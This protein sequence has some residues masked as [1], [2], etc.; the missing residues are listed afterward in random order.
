MSY[1]S[2]E[3]GHEAAAAHLRADAAPL[4]GR[5]QVQKI[6]NR[7]GQ[8]TS[9][10]ALDSDGQ[11]VVVRTLTTAD[12]AVRQSHWEHEIALLSLLSS[13][14]FA[15]HREL[16][17]HEETLYWVRPYVAGRALSIDPTVRP[18]L[19]QA[20]QFGRTL[21]GALQAL[22]SR[23]CLCRNLRPANLI[24]TDV[25]DSTRFVLTDFGLGVASDNDEA[26]RRTVDDVLYL[27]P[28]QAGS[29]DCDVA[30]T[31]DLYSAGALYFHYLSGRPPYEGA[32]V[33]AVLLRHMTAHVPKL[34]SLGLEMPRALD[35]VLQRLL[36]K[37]PRDRYQSAAAV[38]A[39]LERIAAA[40]EAGDADPDFVVGSADRRRTL[41]EPAF[42]G[43]AR[44][45]QQLDLQLKS[46]RLGLGGLVVLET[47]SGGGKS[48][49]LDE[50]TQRARCQGIWVLRGIGTNEVGQ[51]PFQV[52]DG[53]VQDFVAVAACEP[54]WKQ[55]LREQLGDRLCSVTAVLPQVA[56]VLGRDEAGELGPE[57]FAEARSIQALV[58]FLDAL[59]STNRPALVVLDD[60]Q[61]AD[62]SAVKLIL[63]WANARGERPSGGVTVVVAYRSEEVETTHALR[64]LQP[65]LQLR[66]AKFDDEDLR[67]LIE[68]MAGP[69][70]DD[71][72]EAVTS[73]A[74][75]S[76]FMASAALRGLV[77]SG[78]VVA[79]EQGWRIEPL[80]V[81]DMQSSQQAGS[82]LARRIDLLPQQ[83]A[84][85]LSAGAVLGKEF[86][87]RTAV[88]LAGLDVAVALN[89]L[90]LARER[91][92][93]WMRSDGSRCA[94]VHD[95]I[96]ATLLERLDSAE[97]K[98]LHL[99]AAVHLRVQ[100][101]R[102]T[103]ELAY[104][105]DAADEPQQ[106]L[107]FALES[108]EQARA[109][110][111]LETAEQQ[112]Q[113][114]L[115]GA[116]TVNRATRYR[117]LQGLGDVQMLRGRYAPSAELFEQAAEL[118]EGPFAQAEIR[119]KLGELAFKRG[120]IDRAVR[121]FEAAL[122]LLSCYVPRSLPTFFLLF[123]WEAWVQA[124]HTLL[125]GWF[126]GRLKRPPTDAE[127]LSWRLRS[128]LAFGYW[129]A[130]SK[131]HVLWT[132]LR[133]MNLGER[134]PPTLELAQAYSEHAPAMT[135]VPYF[136]RGAAYAQKSFEIRK[137]L[138]DLWGQ[139]QSLAYLGIVHYAG[140]K[141]VEAVDKGR[142]GIRLL[143]RMG[144]YW[145]V[146]IAR[147]QVAAA[148]Y[149][150]GDLPAAIDLARRNYESGFRLGDEQASGISL[151]VWARAAQGK[152]PRTIVDVEMQRVRNDAQAF[153]Q[154]MLG[155]GV[156]YLGADQIEQAAETFA[157]ALQVAREAGVVNA[158][159]APNLAWLATALRLKAERYAG[160]LPTQ[161]R[162][163]LK[164]AAGAALRALWLA[165]RFQN[166]LPHALRELGL[167]RIQL[168]RVRSGMCLL[169]RSI[170][171]AQRQSARYEAAL[172]RR[173]YWQT[174]AELGY[175]DAPREL[176][177]ASTDVQS[178]E[179]AA[180]T[181]ASREAGGTTVRATL[182]L[183]DRFDT[184]LDAGRRI[185]S[186]LTEP[187][188]FEEMRQA[189]VR[190]LR[191][192][193]CFVVRQLA[194]QDGGLRIADD[195][196]LPTGVRRSLLNHCL[197][198]GRAASSG[199]DI[200]L[201]ETEI[202]VV[203]VEASAVCMPVLVRGRIV[204]CLYVVH[205]GIRNLFGDDEKRLAEFVATL[206]GAALEN[207]AGFQQLQDLN[208]TL[209]ARVAE[210]TAAAE[211][212]SQAK[213]QFLAMVSHEIRTPMNG[214]IGMTELTLA[215]PLNT[216]Q[217]SRLGLVKQSAAG[218]LRLLNDLLDFSKIEA[219]K[220]EL[221]SVELDLRDVVGDA[222]QIRAG[223]ASKKGLELVQSI[224][225][226]VPRKLLG[227]PGRLRQVV[228][229]LVGNAVKFTERGEIEV[230]VRVD[231][232]A[233]DKVRLHF[234]VRDTGIGIPADKQ[235]A[236]FEKFQ[237][238]DSSTTR[239][240]GGTGL[241]LSIS[242]E[243]VGLMGGTIW[244]ES[245]PG[246]GSTFH[247]TADFATLPT[248]D[249]GFGR[250]AAI[251]QGLR[252]LV[253]DDNPAQRTALVAWGEEHGM[254][255]A[256]VDCTQAA[257][258]TCNDAAEI[259]LP[260]E[261]LLID[262]E[263]NDED[264]RRLAEEI[265]GL[266]GYAD[267]AIVLLSPMSQRCETA[268]S[269][270]PRT[271]QLSKPAKHAELLAAL[272]EAVCPG[273]GGEQSSAGVDV[274]DVPPLKLLLVED[275]FVN[276]EVAMGFLEMGGHRITTAENGL[277]ALAALERE[278]FDVVLMDVEMPEMDGLT[279]ARTWREREVAEGRRRTPII[280]MTA[281]AVQGYREHCLSHGMDDYVTKPIWPEELFAALKRVT[282]LEAC[283]QPV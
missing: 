271:Q 14:R 4:F 52:L 30:A 237:Q 172:S 189:A 240:Y 202:G 104:H 270:H 126:L 13:D 32:T 248:P 149:R 115:R 201:F 282:S 140:S 101:N 26:G 155:G 62:E 150:L 250:H 47:E 183:A 76:P 103:F 143:E 137:A 50:F 262:S 136:R 119:G 53:V 204:A 38:L 130:R 175:A 8:R 214:I 215:G 132:H 272:A 25:D 48:R 56:E 146:H 147:Y 199:D 64:T 67:R 11:E 159:V 139:G 134:H 59:G 31:A 5:F 203:D 187:T 37:D 96:R 197:T 177:A 222:L 165:L 43:R 273:C 9:Y 84:R 268:G 106:A 252:L 161:R 254:S 105:F 51:K 17:R 107:P 74:D 223:D 114:A 225:A 55:R 138:G 229:N 178:L 259:G 170:A 94:F 243:L 232:A 88:E 164:A 281:H 255:V 235:Q 12:A 257:L 24:L 90:D 258:N 227:D 230:G 241:G 109:R 41:T 125:P 19:S 208:Q 269:S 234:T 95:K 71:I 82:F 224:A 193:E 186:A 151:D 247:F 83:A 182:S 68:S 263:L 283:K 196:R 185:A 1:P 54:Q 124:W 148:L 195:A 113:I 36:R 7:H 169:R 118:A 264:P 242:A 231:A 162:K 111:A 123:L 198:L 69:L 57:A 131:V 226:D 171:V 200:P 190:L 133:G 167:A 245:V 279:A 116:S 228:I 10:L 153:A 61:W 246:Q 207:S 73:M 93:L 238:A 65:S 233:S 87:W 266:S 92:L 80:A 34:R 212:A 191:G 166:D 209:E 163:L 29:L 173:V 102:N 251:V 70:P 265:R 112:Y 194:Q 158:Y 33:G 267:C 278:N 239:Q 129:F 35:E 160:H 157:R 244:V 219:G 49:L 253:V 46:L 180:A 121:S 44:E 205:R 142:E 280:A 28:E 260:I 21:F 220:M 192:E 210:R 168:G 45:L 63:E 18:S 179:L 120:D 174:A 22:H 89:L 277:E 128:R 77:E 27:S 176:A 3:L 117:I 249:E 66:L 188:I 42:V 97:R 217:Q 261:A 58:H 135:L 85:L 110:H 275:G 100:G 145:E 256:A 221:E 141:Y 75:G 181:A 127:R 78:A 79:D 39:D 40:L 81:A 6:L 216:Q 152:L 184:V 154:T 60:C 72:V 99:R 274:G 98:R 16:G 144:D 206:G 108:A 2:E 236:I 23:H 86:A 276:R 15:S 211:A 91:H 20:L 122:R 156:R 213:S 218:L